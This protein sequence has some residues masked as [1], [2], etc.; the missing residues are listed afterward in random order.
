MIEYKKQ[1]IIIGPQNAISYKDIFYLIKRSKIWQGFGFS[2]NAAHFINKYYEDYATASNHIDGMIRVSGITWFT[3]IDHKK[4]HDKLILYKKYN[5]DEYPSYVNF[6]AINV[7]ETKN[8]PV[9]YYG[10]IGVPITFLDKYCPEQFEIV[11]LGIVGSCEFKNNKKMEILKKGMPTGKY[12]YNAKGT[13]YRKYNP[14]KDKKPAAFKDCETGELYS[15]IY[16][17]ILIRR[18]DEN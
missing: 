6:D 7:D 5:S 1:F 11:G 14:K 8:I 13:L 10:V 3:N 2:G 18:K 12:T 16:A 15:S 17:R 9:D 4:R